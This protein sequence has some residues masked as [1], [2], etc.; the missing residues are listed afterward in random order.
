MPFSE[1]FA[2]RVLKVLNNQGNYTMPSIDEI[3]LALWDADPGTGTGGSLTSSEV[4]EGG[5]AAVAIDQTAGGSGT[6]ELFE[7]VT[8]PG[9]SATADLQTNTSTDGDITW[10]DATADWNGGNDILYLCCFGDTL[11]APTHV[12]ADFLWYGAFSGGGATIKAGD[13]AKVSGQNLTLS[14]T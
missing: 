6:G 9:A 4:A 7:V 10:A 14:L 3:S 12:A 11:Q 5:Y 13:T 8:L 2:G 1:E